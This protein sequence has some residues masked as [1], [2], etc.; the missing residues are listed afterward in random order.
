MLGVPQT[1]GPLQPPGSAE[2]G[3][4]MK[5]GCLEGSPGVRERGLWG[6]LGCL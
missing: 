3:W 5:Q 6:T 1:R 2:E 4:L